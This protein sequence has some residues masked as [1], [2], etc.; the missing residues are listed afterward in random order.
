MTIIILLQSVIYHFTDYKIADKYDSEKN[1]GWKIYW[2]IFFR[3][4]YAQ[5]RYFAARSLILNI[6]L[7]VSTKYLDLDFYTFIL[8]YELDIDWCLR[9]LSI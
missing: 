7:A 1:C 4:S 3:K 8:I 5:G 9:I 2:L 6:K